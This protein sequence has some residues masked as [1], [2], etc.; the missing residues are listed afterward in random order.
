MK[1]IIFLFAI[2]IVAIG[3]QA[4]RANKVTATAVDTLN[5]AETVN[6][7]SIE[8]NGAFESLAMQAVCSE[9]GGTSD[10]TLWV[11]GSVDGTSFIKI[12]NVAGLDWFDVFS[13]DTT[14]IAVGSPIFTI[15]DGGIMT[16]VFSK[17]TPFTY[18]R[19]SGTGTSGDTTLITPKYIFKK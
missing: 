1:R 13:A 4:Q 3:A 19:F 18:V 14:K 10:G 6:F 5:G 16:A 12:D 9:L 17:G 8:I 11:E 15:T 2:L 7:A